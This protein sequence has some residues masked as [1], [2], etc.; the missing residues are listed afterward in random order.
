MSD[1]DLQDDRELRARAKR[2]LDQSVED[3]DRTVTLRLQ[4]ARV[5]ALSTGV[6]PR[7]RWVWGGGLAVTA[8]M[9]LAILFWTKQPAKKNHHGPFLEDMELV[10]SAENVELAE[11]LEFYHWLV[12]ADQTG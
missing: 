10:M 1:R 2:L 3:L 6:V 11:D 7:W 9:A 8:V 5:A 12:D 4:R